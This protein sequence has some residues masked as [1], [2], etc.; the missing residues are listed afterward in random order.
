MTAQVF[1]FKSP[2]VEVRSTLDPFWAVTFWIEF[3]SRI[4]ARSR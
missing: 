3:W 2:R 4:Y 1:E